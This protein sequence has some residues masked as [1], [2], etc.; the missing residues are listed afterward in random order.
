MSALISDDDYFGDDEF[1]ELDEIDNER[2]VEVMDFLD[3]KYG[4]N[5]ATYILVRHPEFYRFTALEVAYTLG[6]LLDPTNY[7]Y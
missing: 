3:A 7:K 1:F 4:Q 6:H 2:L 5:G